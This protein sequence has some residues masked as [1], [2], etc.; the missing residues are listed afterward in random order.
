MLSFASL[1]LYF[2]VDAIRTTC[3]NQSISYI[4]KQCLITH[5]EILNNHQP[6]VKLFH[7]FGSRCFIFNFQEHQNKFDVKDDEVVFLGSSIT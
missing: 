2:W 3:F 5:H 1:P 6:N 7:L 4:N